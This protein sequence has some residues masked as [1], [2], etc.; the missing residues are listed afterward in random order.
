M[1]TSSAEFLRC[2][3]TS[4]LP[5]RAVTGRGAFKVQRAWLT[6]SPWVAVQE[7]RAATV[8]PAAR[9][10]S[11]CHCQRHPGPWASSHSKASG[12]TGDEGM[13][14][15]GRQEPS[16]EAQHPWEIN[17]SKGDRD[18]RS[19]GA[20]KQSASE[21]QHPWAVICALEREWSRDFW[22]EPLK[23]P[24]WKLRNLFIKKC[25]DKQNGHNLNTT[26]QFSATRDKLATEEAE[27]WR[28]FI[29]SSWVTLSDL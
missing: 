29:V 10:E 16:H 13:T 9:G 15:V 7:P 6:A 20:I 1:S 5:L 18:L 19:T 8:N 3:A 2:G 4:L 28:H 11:R 24:Q 21:L 14:A 17:T 27:A 26:F 22:V 12:G 23:R 25:N